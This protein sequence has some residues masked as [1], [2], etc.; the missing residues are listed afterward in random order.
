MIPWA[1][2]P[3]LVGGTTYIPSPFFLTYPLWLRSVINYDLTIREK[4]FPVGH[5][6]PIPSQ[7]SISA[8][9][10]F[11]CS[12][13]LTTPTHGLPTNRTWGFFL[14]HIESLRSTSGF[15]R[16]VDDVYNWDAR[17]AGLFAERIGIGLAGYLLWNYYDVIQITDAEKY[18]GRLNL[19]PTHPFYRKGLSYS[20]TGRYKPDFFCLTRSGESVV[21][22]S[23]GTIGRPGDL[24]TT[25][26]HGKKQVQ[27][28]V[29]VGVPLRST[30]NS[31]V[32][33]SNLRGESDTVRSGKDSGVTIQDPINPESAI[34]VALS[35]REM[36]TDGYSK[37]F[38]FIGRIDLSYQLNRE[39]LDPLPDQF[40]KQITFNRGEEKY[41]ELQRDGGV[42]VGLNRKVYRLLQ[43]DD[44]SGSVAS[45]IG[46]FHE[47]ERQLLH[48]DEKSLL[49]PNGIIFDFS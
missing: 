26:N 17:L 7:I 10:L 27:S 46:I 24:T 42:K 25:L 39:G 40:I 47:Q 13:I 35:Q 36:I 31:L 37:I 43:A 14:N 18:I 4:N 12:G 21:A 2:N 8:R 49:L 34:E 32:F 44:L 11:I 30:V 33:G 1:R 6:Y 38:N 20:G 48:T 19:S 23:K 22:E 9:D 29:P 15:L 45:I 41:V 5:P 3:Y 16:V 28:V